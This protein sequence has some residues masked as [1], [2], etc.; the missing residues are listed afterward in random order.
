MSVHSGHSRA[1]RQWPYG[2]R[3]QTSR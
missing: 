1:G 3:T 2:V